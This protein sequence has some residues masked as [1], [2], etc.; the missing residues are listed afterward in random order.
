MPAE[1]QPTV[2][3]RRMGNELRA[4]REAAGVSREDVAERLACDLTK[5]SRI[6][7]GRSG[8]RKVEL[9]A[10]LDMYGVT[11]RVRRQALFTISRD[12]RQKGW[13]HP[14]AELLRPSAQDLLAMESEAESILAY[15]SVLIPG[16]LQTEGYAHALIKSGTSAADDDS[17]AKRVTLRMERKQIFQ[18][19]RPPRLIAV[20][21]E[22][23]LRRTIGGPDVMVGQLCHLIEACD[24][25]RIALHVV[26]LEI[27][28]HPGLDGPFH[29]ISYPEEVGLD[30]VLLDQRYGGVY[31]EE[32]EQVRSYRILFDHI[33][34][35]ALSS[36]QSKDL[37]RGLIQG[38]ESRGSGHD[39][40]RS[41]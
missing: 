34:S 39:A 31:V 19:E 24:P 28:A 16:L 18:R 1:R 30:V 5:I 7:L 27:G 37:I 29:L 32:P 40:A 23:A 9:E 33:R 36:P 10:M 12:S 22:A 26:P 17:V 21:D 8:V 4:M 6:E 25:P 15:E 41:G 13:W 11:D 20:I 2:R 38:L 3:R 35:L 14:Y